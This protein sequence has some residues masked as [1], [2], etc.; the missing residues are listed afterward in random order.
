MTDFS[1]DADWYDG[2]H[3]C[4]FTIIKRKSMAKKKEAKKKISVIRV[5]PGRFSYPFL[6]E[7][8]SG[9]L[10]PTDQYQTD[11]LIE[12]KVFNEKCKE[13]QDKVLELGTELLG[14]DYTLDTKTCP[15]HVP[16][17]DTDLPNNKG[18]MVP[19]A[20]RGCILIKAKV[21]D[22]NPPPTILAPT[23]PD[24]TKDFPSLTLDEVKEIKGG[25]WGYINVSVFA[26]EAGDGGVSFGLQGGQFW[27][28]GTP[29]GQGISAVLESAEDL[30]VDEPT[31][32][33]VV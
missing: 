26:Y 25:D 16:F 10:Y 5:G 18:V 20:Q 11:F 12:K 9:G 4:R 28:K 8:N 27:K 1:D 30:E 2:E 13:L 24:K 31:E 14:D 6:A 33:H 23:R 19:E 3:D 17:R 32:E 7:P 29:F 22:G 21:K 15:Y